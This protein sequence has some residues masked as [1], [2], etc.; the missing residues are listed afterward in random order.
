MKQTVPYGSRT[1]KS[2]HLI[3]ITMEFRENKVFFVIII[4]TPKL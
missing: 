2:N 1:K 3:S 4:P